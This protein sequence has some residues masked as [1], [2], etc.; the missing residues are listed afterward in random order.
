EFKAARASVLNAHY[1]SEDV[2]RGIW[3][4]MDRL[5]VN[6]GRLLEP[7]MGVGNFFGLMPPEKW[8]AML[9]TG[10]ELDPLTGAIAKQLYQSADVRIQGFEKAL[11]PEGFYDA[12]IGNV[13]FGTYKIH[14]PKYNQLNL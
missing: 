7:S 4:A 1:T 14:D 8:T 10:I 5:G 13:P 2:V 3:D 11:L 12:A 6:A 9:K